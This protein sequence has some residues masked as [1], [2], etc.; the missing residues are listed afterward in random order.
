M[1]HFVT[2]DRLPPELQFPPDLNDRIQFDADSRRLYFRGFMSKADFD[3]LCHLSDDWSYRRPLEDLFR[4]CMTPPARP[5]GVRGL[6]AAL[7]SI[8]F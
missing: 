1:D 5:K 4:K 8:G 3:R 7:T 6:I 2:L